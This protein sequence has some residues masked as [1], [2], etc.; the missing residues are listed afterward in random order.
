MLK[1][2]G[3]EEENK[4]EWRKGRERGKEEEKEIERKVGK[5][6]GGREAREAE[7]FPCHC[8]EPWSEHS[9][10]VRQT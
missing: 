7:L 5:R 2:R 4:K 3:R 1:E 9:F 6:E 8:L 10:A